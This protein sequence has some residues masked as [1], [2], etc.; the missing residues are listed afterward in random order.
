MNASGTGISLCVVYL[1]LCAA[2]SMYYVC[3]LWKLWMGTANA[4][5]IDVDDVCVCLVCVLI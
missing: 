2:L 3:C 5:A 4:H 1:S